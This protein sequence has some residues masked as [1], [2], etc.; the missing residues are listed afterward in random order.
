[1]APSQ[2]QEPVG[3]DAVQPEPAAAHQIPTEQ[4]PA[5][6][7]LEAVSNSISLIAVRLPYLFLGR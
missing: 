7:E 2:S 1:M 4:L 3:A 6:D 5:N